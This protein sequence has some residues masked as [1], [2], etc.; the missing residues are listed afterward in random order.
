DRSAASVFS[1]IAR[2][3][4]AGWSREASARAAVLATQR[5]RHESEWRQANTAAAAMVTGGPPALDQ[6]DGFPDLVRLYLYNA[7]RAAESPARVKRLE[8][9]ARA[10]DKR[11][12]GDVLARYVA[13][14]AALPFARRT[15][16]GPRY[17]DLV[18]GTLSA[19][20]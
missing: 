8:P 14:V 16:L 11:S 15:A 12:G 17:A 4:E 6:V 19:S 20:Q 2:G 3:G 18:A 13:R 1:Q 5:A 7:V 10:I 9:L